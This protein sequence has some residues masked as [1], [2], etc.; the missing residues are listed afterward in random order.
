MERYGPTTR[1]DDPGL[2][3]GPGPLD[4]SPR[5]PGRPPLPPWWQRRI[6]AVW[7]I[8]GL[9]LVVFHAWHLSAFEPQLRG[10]VAGNLLTSA[11][12]LQGS[13]TSRSGT[14]CST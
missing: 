6:V 12:H 8:I 2:M 11:I 10:W 14:S 3:T 9:N 7:V 13:L 4:Q 1:S 5:I